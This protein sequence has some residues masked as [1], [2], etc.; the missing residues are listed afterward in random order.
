M[1]TIY[2]IRHGKPDFPGGGKMCLGL[3][4]LP[5]GSLG[6]LQGALLGAF[7]AERSLTEAFSSRL[8]RARETASLTGLPVTVLDGLEELYAGRWDGLSFEEIRKR[9][10]ETFA[11]RRQTPSLPPPGGESG[12]HGC[13]RFSAAFELAV[14]QSRGDIAVFAHASVSQLLLCK[15]RNMPLGLARET[16]LPYGC[17]TRLILE[18]GIYLAEDVGVSPRP[19]LD[20]NVCLRLL[21]ALDT[22]P[23]LLSHSRAVAKEALRITRA[24]AAAGMDLDADQIFAAAMLHDISRRDDHHAAAGAAL[25]ENLGYPGVAGIIRQHHD[26]EDPETIDG[27]G[28]VCLADKLCLGGTIVPLDTRFAASLGGCVT[29]EARSAHG[30]RYAAAA[31]IAEKINA[32]CGK[33]IVK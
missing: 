6:R 32:I 3:T 28:V 33:D 13:D 14:S 9:W 20:E 18:D 4:D 2:L 22:P 10:P 30:R 11:L 23:N 21:A 7:F 16:P 5:L 15:I 25:L 31:G 17:Y 27:A 8:S 29:V 26:P 12:E 19:P 24:L 1:R